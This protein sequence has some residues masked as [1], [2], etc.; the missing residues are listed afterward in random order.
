LTEDL[1]NRRALEKNLPRNVRDRRQEA[2]GISQEVLEQHRNELIQETTKRR[3][4]FRKKDSKTG[5]YCVLCQKFI[6]LS[7]R[8][9]DD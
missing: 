9:L 7:H 2:A 8:R 6:C 4:Y 1:I 5:F 3:C